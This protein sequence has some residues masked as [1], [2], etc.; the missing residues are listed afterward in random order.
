VSAAAED[1]GCG[2]APA[3]EGPRVL[4]SG[5]GTGGHVNPA[6]ATAAALTR[7]G[8]DVTFVGT[9]HGLEQRLVP[10]AG[11][12]LRTVPAAPLRGRRWQAVAA[13]ATVARAGWALGGVLRAE[14]VDAAVTFGGYTA[15]PLAVAARLARTPLVIHEQNAVPGLANRLAARWAT[16]VAVSVPGVAQRFP[17]PER[18][19]L[20]GNPVRADVAAG[21]LPDRA[22]AAER[23]GLDPSRPTLLVFGGSLGARRLNDAVLAAT[24]LW[25]DPGRVQVLHAAG[26]GDHQRVA[27]AWQA[28]DRGDLRVVWRPYVDDMADA[29]AACDLALC[30]AGATTIAE[31]TLAGVPSVLVPYPHAVADEQAANAT[32]LAE[33]GAAV[34]VA[35][36]ELDGARLVAEVEPLL[37]DPAALAAMAHA[38]RALGRGDAADAVAALVMAAA[39]EEP[40][41]A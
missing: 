19:H 1:G 17:R 3:T 12:A 11:F 14:G 40:A 10:A 34:V 37:A 28:L 6:L 33:A 18:V 20:T 39:G 7:A 27:S 21:R 22:A 13:A 41:D 24:P 36:A 16:A 5:G 30:R 4:I 29:Y 8:A 26:V 35:D 9:E 31:L 32:A 23:L 25:D 38:G 15:G 2:D